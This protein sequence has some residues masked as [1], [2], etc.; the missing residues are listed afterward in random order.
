MM[1]IAMVLD[2]KSLQG[3]RAFSVDPEPPGPGGACRCWAALC[4][5]FSWMQL[6]VG[7]LG[8]AGVEVDPKM[9]VVS[10]AVNAN[11][12]IISHSG[13]YLVGH[14]KAGVRSPPPTR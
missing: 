6:T 2:R 14:R 9:G 13:V 7:V 1:C 12:K 10:V 3:Q 8:E 11:K 4:L 5:L